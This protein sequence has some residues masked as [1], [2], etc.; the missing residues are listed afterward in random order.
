MSADLARRAVACPRWRWMPGML[1]HTTHDGGFPR[2]PAGTSI[3][4]ETLSALED[5]VIERM[6]A[7][8]EEYDWTADDCG[9]SEWTSRRFLRLASEQPGMVFADGTSGRGDSAVW[10]DGA[11]FPDLDD[12]AT[13]GCLL[14]LVREAWKD[15][16]IYV[17]PKLNGQIQIEGWEVCAFVP[18]L[19]SVLCE[20]STE[21]AALVAALEGAP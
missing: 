15:L 1:T 12:A 16:G 17:A 11:W 4:V 20:G 8:R 10:I 7:S 18:H 6:F 9:A 13:K 14:A 5:C 2:C 19:P 3:R 21:Q